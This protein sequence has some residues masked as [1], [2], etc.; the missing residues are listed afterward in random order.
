MVLC[1]LSAAFL[2]S[3]VFYYRELGCDGGWYSYPA[4]ALSRGGSPT[5]NLTSVE[6]LQK[7]KGIT[8]KFGFKTYKSIRT[9]YTTLWFKYVSQNI[10][11]LKFLSLLELLVTVLLAY[12]LI[13]ALCQNTFLALTLTSIFANGKPLLLSAGGDFRPDNILTAFTCLTFLALFKARYLPGY[14]PAFLASTLMI[15]VHVTAVIPFICLIV[16]FSIYRLFG[17][18]DAWKH[19]LALTCLAIATAA[20]FLFRHAIFDTLLMVGSQNTGFSSGATWKVFGMYSSGI[21]HILVKELHRWR[22]YFLFSNVAELLVVLIAAGTLLKHIVTSK[23]PE[24]GAAFLIAIIIGICC[25][26]LLDPHRRGFHAIPMSPLFFGFLAYQLTIHG[27]NRKLVKLTLAGLCVM[28]SLSSVAVGAEILLKGNKS[29]YNIHR[30]RETLHQVVSKTASQKQI[31]GPTEI[32]PFFEKETD[33][34]LIDNTRDG[35]RL[36][37]LEPH[38][39]NINFVIL[40]KDYLAHNWKKKFLDHFPGFTLTPIEEFGSREAFFGIYTLSQIPK[41]PIP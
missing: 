26:A 32:W 12:L 27:M 16:F 1:F 7:I 31:I 28:A 19:F 17:G 35:S 34:V 13:R 36:E 24:R 18:S 38:I 4:L 37:G 8:A 5:E 39:N 6:E 15:L 3:T 40:N 11:M 22:S 21:G 10:Y 20:V 9:L 41:F 29:G 30:V 23:K 33:V 25:Y 14:L 2:F